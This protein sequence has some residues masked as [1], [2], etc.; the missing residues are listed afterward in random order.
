MRWAVPPKLFSAPTPTPLH[1]AAFQKPRSRTRLVLA[2][3]ASRCHS[4]SDTKACTTLTPC[5]APGCS[6]APWALV[7][8]GCLG[9]VR[10]E[11]SATNHVCVGATIWRRVEHGARI[12]DLLE[13]QGP[14]GV[15]SRP[16]APALLSSPTYRFLLEAGP[17]TQEAPHAFADGK[18]LEGDSCPGINAGPARAWPFATRSCAGASK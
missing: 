2:F 17:K 16:L 18:T 12:T 4:S 6:R 3:K 15:V 10:E 9:E 8:C 11:G 14:V 5:A 7:G 13:A 1:V